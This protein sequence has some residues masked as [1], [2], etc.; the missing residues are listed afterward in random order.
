MKLEIDKINLSNFSKKFILISLD[1]LIIIFAVIFSYS[2]RLELN[3]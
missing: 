3:L 1:I 2:L